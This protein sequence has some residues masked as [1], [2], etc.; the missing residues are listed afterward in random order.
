MDQEIA[1]RLKELIASLSKNYEIEIIEQETDLGHI[2]I[3]FNTSPKIDLPMYIRL[4]KSSSAKALRKEFPRIYRQLW[5]N[6]FWSSS[7]FLASTG[8]VSLDVIRK[9]VESQGK[10]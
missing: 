3:L 10:P 6:A 8:Q 4:I 2:H 5:G 9:Y 7:Y 1:E